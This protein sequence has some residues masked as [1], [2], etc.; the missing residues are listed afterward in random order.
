VKRKTLERDTVTPSWSQRFGYD[1]EGRLN[2]WSQGVAAANGAIATPADRQIWNLTLV[3][4]WA[5]TTRNGAPETR[6]HTSVHEIASIDRGA[7]VIPLG[8][9]AKGNLTQDDSGQTYRWDPENRMTSAFIPAATGRAAGWASYRY[10]ALGRR[11]AK[12]WQG[13]TTRYWH[14]GAQIVREYDSLS[15]AT[16]NEQT[17]DGALSNLGLSP[18]ESGSGILD[19]ATLRINFQPT[20]AEIPAGYL[21]DKG[22]TY[23]ARTNG[24]TYGWS[25]SRSATA[26][27]RNVLRDPVPDTH[28][29]LRSGST[30][31]TWSVAVANG[32]YHT[33]VVAGDPGSVESTNHLTIN[34]VTLTDPDPGTAGQPA[35]QSG[36]LDGWV[37]SVTVTNGKITIASAPGAVLPKLSMIEVGPALG[38]LTAAASRLEARITRWQSAIGSGAALVAG[39]GRGFVWGTYVD[40]VVAYRQTV[41][42]V[43]GTYYPHYNHL[44]SVAA[45]T[46]STTVV[47]RYTYDAYGRQ[48]ITSGGGV[49]RSK[50]AVGWDRGFTGRYHDR[51]TGLIYFMYRPYSL[52]L[53]R[54]IGRDAYKQFPQMVAKEVGRMDAAESALLSGAYVPEWAQ[55]NDP[56]TAG[57]GYQDGYGLYT[58]YFAQNDL[59]PL[60]LACTLIC[61]RCTKDNGTWQ[62]KCT[63]TD[64]AGGTTD[65]PANTGKNSPPDDP[66]K[67]PYGPNG[68]LPPGTYDLPTAYS[69]K[70]KTKLPSPT[71]TGTPGSVKTPNG[72]NRS[73]IRMHKPGRSDGCITCDQG[74]VDKVN[75]CA[76]KGGMKLIIKDNG[77]CDTCPYP[78]KAP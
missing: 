66:A 65:F 48:T 43:I 8:Y 26:R 18:D 56:P 73:G 17:S 45:L 51:E 59:D 74:N 19:V 47:E 58:G 49:V 23:A 38:T 5:S 77:K 10:D 33:A 62:Y 29:G 11:V 1:A 4:D 41:G 16:A 34:G 27:Q 52:S 36:D 2:D 21:A 40:E 25:A 69:P 3:G 37:S 70:F 72:S 24:L 50:S 31:A 67:D 61:N 42:G 76:K 44:Y 28:I 64:D 32:T 53:G 6:T 13:I 75:D 22:R 63:L 15:T 7:G 14:D 60:G 20:A 54:F 35:Y 71:N 39:A 57:D 55:W 78:G 46:D 30:N 9:D 12:T 68:P